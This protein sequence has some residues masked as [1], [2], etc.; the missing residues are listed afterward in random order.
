MILAIA[1]TSVVVDY[2]RGIDPGR[3]TLTRLM[4]RGVVATSVVVEAELWTGVADDAEA[5]AVRR[6]LARIGSVFRYERAEAR[7]AGAL[8]RYVLGRGE[9]PWQREIDLL[10]AGA[11][12]A[13]RIPVLTDN[14]ADFSD[15]PGVRVVT[16]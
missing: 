11:C 2:L 7:A 5:R 1:D 14:V 9:K 8:R 10:I 13:R 3:R 4:V 6:V 15:L 12:V 16:P